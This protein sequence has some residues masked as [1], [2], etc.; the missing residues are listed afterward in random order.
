MFL[1]HASLPAFDYVRPASLADASHFLAEHPGEARPF[2]GGTDV[3]VR[4]RDGAWQARYLVDLKHLD[5]LQALR[6]DAAQGLTVGAAVS[7]NRVAADPGVRARYP[8]LAEAA[9]SVGSYP[10]R[11]R[12]TLGGNACN[13]SPAGDTLGAGLVLE[14]Q[15]LVLGPAGARQLAL[16]DFLRGPGQTALQSG[17]IVTALRYPPPPAGCA[18][19]YLK[20]GRTSLG[21]VALVGAAALGFR[22]PG[23]AS[24]FRFRVALVAAAATPLLFTPSALSQQA[25]DEAALL[26]AAE[27]VGA[28]CA[29]IDD[30]RASAEYRRLMAATLARRALLDVWGRIA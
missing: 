20:L 17:E 14:A 12:A 15:V 25:V 22:D 13:A 21:D 29:P 11:A 28:A 19:R 2:M 8:V 23:A 4:L 10:L 24:G 26:S 6:F 18:A 7:L 1:P 30:I 3:F 9:G 16:R 27:A 5:G